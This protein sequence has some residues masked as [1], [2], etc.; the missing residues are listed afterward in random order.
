[1]NFQIKWFLDYW[2]LRA[3]F[4]TQ[5]PPLLHLSWKDILFGFYLL[6]QNQKWKQQNNV[7]NL[8]EFNNKDNRATSGVFF[9]NFEQI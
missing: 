1:M 9:I 4:R 3:A 2:Q 6:V 8:F 5:W 7:W